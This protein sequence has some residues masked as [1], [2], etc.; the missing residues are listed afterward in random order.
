MLHREL[1]VHEIPKK[2]RPLISR[3]GKNYGI[4]FSG[5][6]EGKFKTSGI[7]RRKGWIYIATL[8]TPKSTRALRR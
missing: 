5:K 6:M 2:S 8:Q 1:L 3:G 7:G 4:S